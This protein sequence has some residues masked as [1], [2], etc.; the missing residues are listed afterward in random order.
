MGQHDRL[1]SWANGRFDQGRIDVVGTQLDIDEHRYRTEL[2][3]RVD[4]G[5]ETGGNADDLVTFADR[6]ITQAR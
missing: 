4:R 3:N 6:P 2:Q 5:G 1:G